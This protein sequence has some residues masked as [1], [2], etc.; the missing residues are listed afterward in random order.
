MEEVARCTVMWQLLSPAK[1]FC[2]ILRTRFVSSSF[3][4]ECCVGN[5]IIASS[6]IGTLT[7]PTATNV[8]WESPWACSSCMTA[9]LD[10][11]LGRNAI[12]TARQTG[13]AYGWEE[14]TD[15]R[16]EA[17][18]PRPANG[19]G[20]AIG[21]CAR[22]RGR[23]PDAVQRLQTLRN[24]LFDWRVKVKV[25]LSMPWERGVAALANLGT[26]WRWVVSFT[27]RPLYL[28]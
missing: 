18:T 22:G 24:V 3:S 15:H 6:S 13:V 27:P 26:R 20:T 7:L 9:V 8:T 16:D 5:C 11:P 4:A 1:I 14:Y 21:W 28:M 12:I 19:G 2:Q 10:S 17:V 23:R 25:F